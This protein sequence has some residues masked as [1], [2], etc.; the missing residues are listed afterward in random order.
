MLSRSSLAVAGG[1]AKKSIQRFDKPNDVPC[2][3]L[4][5]TWARQDDSSD[6][7]DVSRARPQQGSN[8]DPAM[9]VSRQLVWWGEQR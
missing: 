4:S 2:P 1:S 3:P 8:P 7:E 6:D 9:C 5:E